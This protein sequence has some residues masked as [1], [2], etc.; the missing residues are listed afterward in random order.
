MTVHSR[1]YHKDWFAYSSLSMAQIRVV[2]RPW[3]FFAPGAQDLVILIRLVLWMIRRLF[4]V[5]L[6][7]PEARLLLKT[8]S[9]CKVRDE[10]Q[11][12]DR[13]T[14]KP[15]CL[16]SLAVFLKHVTME[17]LSIKWSDDRKLNMDAELKK[18]CFKQY[19]ALTSTGNKI[20]ENKL[21][22]R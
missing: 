7:E 20:Q 1:N 3:E 4:F 5:P 21:T 13:N 18:R 8:G 6:L 14:S 22:E 12:N 2:C 19:I 16:Q 15:S 11:R 9:Y 17:T 10:Y